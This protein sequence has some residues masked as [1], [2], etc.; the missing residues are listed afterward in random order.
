MQTMNL[1]ETLKQKFGDIFTDVTDTYGIHSVTLPLNQIYKVMLGLYQDSE[2]GFNFLTDL[3]GVH[4]PDKKG[5]EF[6]VV[7]HLMNLRTAQRLRL[8]IF[9]PKE[10]P[11]VPS[12]TG[13]YAT[14]NWMERETWDF[15]GIDFVGHPDLR[16]ILNMD[17]MKD[18]PMR[19]EFPLEDPFR[20]D[21]ADYQFGR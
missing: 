16:R 11:Q 21:K 9:V 4:Y 17:E 8:K 1:V 5:G 3:C 19:K 6:G 2:L 18:F 20:K 14:A 10:A 13:I 12:M 15:Y 7:Y